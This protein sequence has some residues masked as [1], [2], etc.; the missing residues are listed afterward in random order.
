MAFLRA[1]GFATETGEIRKSPERLGAYT[2]SLKRAKIVALLRSKKLLDEF[3][4]TNWK[5]G[6]TPAGKK[7]LNRYDQ[8]F[9]IST[10]RAWAC[11]QA[12]G[13]SGSIFL[14]PTLLW[15]AFQKS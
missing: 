4:E 3:I 15:E 5:F 7:K 11:V 2:T 10:G 12:A 9:I 14:R 1:T 8:I 6:L 13:W